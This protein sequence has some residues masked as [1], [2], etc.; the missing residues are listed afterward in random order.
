M[1]T[2]M[3]ELSKKHGQ[4]EGLVINWQFLLACIGSFKLTWGHCF[5]IQ[6]IA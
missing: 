3:G 2:H 4:I 5:R 6:E 1:N